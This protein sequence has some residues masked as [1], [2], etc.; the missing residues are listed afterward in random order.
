M[1]TLTHLCVDRTRVACRVRAP[2]HLADLGLGCVAAWGEKK[3]L[4]PSV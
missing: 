2:A 4:L 1:Y 3:V